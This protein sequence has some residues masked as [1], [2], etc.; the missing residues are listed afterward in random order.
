MGDRLMSGTNNAGQS[1]R[2]LSLIS[3]AFLTFSLLVGASCSLAWGGNHQTANISTAKEASSSLAGAMPYAKAGNWEKV[4]SLLRPYV[5]LHPE[6]EV[7]WVWLGYGEF[8]LHKFAQATVHLQHAVRIDP[9]DGRAFYFLGLSFLE[10]GR[11]YKAYQA[12]ITT[13]KFEPDNSVVPYYIGRLMVDAG[14]L[15]E[16]EKWLRQVD[17]TSPVSYRALYYRGYCNEKLGS[18]DEAIKLYRQSL[19]QCILADKAFSLPYTRLAKVL[20]RM[21]KES[22]ARKVLQEGVSRAPDGQ[23]LTTYGEFLIHEHEYD[24]ARAVLAQA[25]QMDPSLP[26]PHYILGRL[27]TKLGQDSKAEQELGAYRQLKARQRSAWEKRHLFQALQF[28]KYLAAMNPTKESA[29][30]AVKNTSP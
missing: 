21:K 19:Q 27:L 24:K 18:S 28:D 23:L 3:C 20:M 5:E 7:A 26:D 8:K 14:R 16:A 10:M 6:K 15:D 30:S 9:Q 13:M 1:Q 17:E 29:G 11:P 2:M 12:W 22:D 25:S 4:V